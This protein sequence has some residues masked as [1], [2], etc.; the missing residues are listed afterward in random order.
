MISYHGFSIDK[1]KISLMGYL[2]RKMRERDI[3]ASGQI[4]PK[5]EGGINFAKNGV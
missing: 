2:S 4:L 3:N 5:K 1:R